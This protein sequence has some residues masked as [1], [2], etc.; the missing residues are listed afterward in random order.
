MGVFTE[1][2]YPVGRCDE[3]YQHP[4]FRRLSRFRLIDGLRKAFGNGNLTSRIDQQLLPRIML[5]DLVNA[6]SLA[7]HARAINITACP[8]N[9]H[10]AAVSYTQKLKKFLFFLSLLLRVFYQR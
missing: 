6:P 10:G 1:T 7:M 9:T 4:L 2:V 8:S 3:C 5:H